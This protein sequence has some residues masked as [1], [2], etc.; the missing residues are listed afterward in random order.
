MLLLFGCMLLSLSAGHM[1]SFVPLRAK[2]FEKGAAPNGTILVENSVDQVNQLGQFCL[3][4]HASGVGNS[5][6]VGG[7][8]VPS[9]WTVKEILVTAVCNEDCNVH[10]GWIV[11]IYQDLGNGPSSSPFI[12]RYEFREQL[13]SGS[14]SP[15]TLFTAKITLTTPIHLVKGK[16]WL[17]AKFVGSTLAGWCVD[18]R[19]V[20]RKRGEFFSFSSENMEKEGQNLTLLPPLFFFCDIISPKNN[21]LFFRVNKDPMFVAEIAMKRGT[22]LPPVLPTA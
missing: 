15:S 12:S 6:P 10:N 21:P 16:Y 1:P 20:G 11:D 3:T 19:K 4:S 14:R 13:V 7:F 2:T 17:S 8:R 5:E 22:M 18:N 9:P